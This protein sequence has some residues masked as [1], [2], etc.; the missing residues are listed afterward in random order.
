L[1]EYSAI[2]EEAVRPW[3][4]HPERL[5]EDLWPDLVLREWQRKALRSLP[6]GLRHA[7]RTAR[8]AGKSILLALLAWWWAFT[9][10]DRGLV[11]LFV[12][13]WR[14]AAILWAALTELWHKSPRLRALCP[15]WE[16]LK[17][18][19]R[20]ERGRAV[21]VAVSSEGGEF[22]EGFHSPSLLVLG[23]ECKA[24]SDDAFRSTRGWLASAEETLEIYA[25]TPGRSTGFFHRLFSDERF[26][27]LRVKASDV[28]ELAEWEKEMRAEYDE[29]DPLLRTQVDADFAGS[30]EDFDALL[31]LSL[32]EPAFGR[33]TA[34]D[35][36][37]W[38]RVLGVDPAGGGSN[39][40]A[41]CCRNG[42]IIEGI[43]TWVGE[44]DQRKNAA[45]VVEIA[46][47]FGPE[48]AVI[49][50]T[51]LGDGIYS[52]LAEIAA[53]DRRF[54]G[55]FR[56]VP[57]IAAHSPAKRDAALFQNL[58][59]SIWYKIRAKYFETSTLCLPESDRRLAAQLAALTVVLDTKGRSRVVDPSPSPDRADSVHLALAYDFIASA[60]YG[61]IIP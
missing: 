31:P 48:A 15:G 32:I 22:I 30:A 38:P 39:E 56:A 47:R 35:G 23:D 6:A 55:R 4:E 58:K 26:Q 5:I 20:D 44:A 37:L 53:E 45:R 61:V 28:P 52:R 33:T 50:K 12:S 18:S 9:R 59:T 24:I 19:V 16:I 57:F 13:S 34:P 54:G 36:T 49:D 60:E 1:S 17:D 40:F 43:E 21:I 27:V 46:R 41:V 10:G 8:G 29:R 3:I 7:W 25:S 2:V 11:I 14:Q 42:P 51:G